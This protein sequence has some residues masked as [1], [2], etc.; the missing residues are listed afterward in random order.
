MGLLRGQSPLALYPELDQSELF[1]GEEDEEEEDALEEDLRADL[2]DE[3]NRNSSS[4]LDQSDLHDQLNEHMELDEGRQ[5]PSNYLFSNPAAETLFRNRGEPKTSATPQSE[6]RYIPAAAHPARPQTSQTGQSLPSNQ[7]SQLSKPQTPARNAGA[8]MRQLR[9]PTNVHKQ[10]WAP[11]P[12]KP[13]AEAQ[14]CATIDSSASSARL[15]GQSSVRSNDRECTSTG[16]C[17]YQREQ[18]PDDYASAFRLAELEEEVL[19][20]HVECV[21][22]DAALLTREGDLIAQI[23]NE[24]RHGGFGGGGAYV[25]GIAEVARHKIAIYSELLRKAEEYTLESLQGS[26]GGR[27]SGR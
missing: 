21:K 1:A 12:T 16:S 8:K 17:G 4:F 7:S 15:S 14:N 5:E 19:G 20:M 9:P 11:Q 3:F 24:A 6:L 27:L 2:N 23:Q 26:R 22:T 18:Q 25:G 13:S 10:A